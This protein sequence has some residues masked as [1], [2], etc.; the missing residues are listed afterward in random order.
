MGEGIIKT[1]KPI[2]QNGIKEGWSK[3]LIQ[4]YYRRDVNL[5]LK[6]HFNMQTVEQKVQLQSIVNINSFT[7]YGTKEKIIT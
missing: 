2:F 1:L 6:G 3:H 5:H 7:R 4:N